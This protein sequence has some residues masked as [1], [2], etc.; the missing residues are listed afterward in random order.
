M[1]LKNYERRSEFAKSYA[2]AYAEGYA[3]GV[4]EGMVKVVLIV[5]EARGVAV[6]DDVRARV[7]GCTD[8]EQLE[9]WVKLAA[10]IDPAEEFVG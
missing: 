7:K 9:R 6:S 4:R 2:E 3:R 5:L 1:D 10:V 8:I